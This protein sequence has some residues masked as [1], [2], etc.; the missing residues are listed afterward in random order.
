MAQDKKKKKTKK[1]HSVEKRYF[2]GENV[3]SLGFIHEKNTSNK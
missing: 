3:F 1:F 2:C